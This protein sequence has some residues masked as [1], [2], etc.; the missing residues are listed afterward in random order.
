M[1]VKVK[2]GLFDNIW[3]AIKNSG[4]LPFIILTLAGFMISGY[5]NFKSNQTLILMSGIRDRQEG[6][7]L[8]LWLIMYLAINT[9]WIYFVKTWRRCYISVPI[10]QYVN[11]YYLTLIQ[12]ADMKWYTEL[13][14]RKTHP[15]NVDITSGTHALIH[16]IDTLIDLIEPIIK[17]CSSISVLC[18]VAGKY[19]LIV[20]V[21]VSILVLLGCIIL[22]WNY[23]V[24]KVIKKQITPK[25]EYVRTLA[26]NFLTEIINGHGNE[27]KKLMLDTIKSSRDLEQNHRNKLS[28]YY[29]WIEGVQHMLVGLG[30]WLISGTNNLYTIGGIYTIV[31][32]TCEKSW[33]LFNRI[34]GMFITGAD[35]GNLEYILEQYQPKIAS[36]D[37]AEPFNPSTYIQEFTHHRN[38]RLG[39][40][41]GCGKSTYMQL[42]VE[43]IYS[44]HENVIVYLPQL[45]NV[46][47]T[48]HI[49]AYQYLT[50]FVHRYVVNLKQEIL[51]YC[52]AVG[53]NHLINKETIDKPFARPS[54]GEQK[55]LVVLQRILPLLIN[56]YHHGKKIVCL[57][58]VSTGLDQEARNRMY[59]LLNTIKGVH[60]LVID[61]DISP[62]F[63]G[64]TKMV[65]SQPLPEL[66]ILPDK[67]SNN[68]QNIGLIKYILSFY[69]DASQQLPTRVRQRPRVWLTDEI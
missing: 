39:G 33:W 56:P 28:N 32:S 51:A 41:S 67:R 21:F 60:I 65:K 31:N 54:G 11:N 59:R 42:L 16:V 20:F 52:D 64:I 29:S 1:M 50:L 24:Q 7:Q 43:K 17:L 26:T 53:L 19:S 6:L 36:K 8:L 23:H 5:I 10:E 40:D 4:S 69:S 48:D 25:N 46:P 45:T 66:E 14:S 55:R 27:T 49:T 22:R 12:R 47:K 44:E 15:L 13:E 57:D 34:H 61:H 35:W 30:T 58:E 68:L 63:G 37:V 9:L 2:S 18:F 3:I 38:I 62:D